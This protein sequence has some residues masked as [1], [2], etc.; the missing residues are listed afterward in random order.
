MWN[1]QNNHKIGCHKLKN[2][3]YDTV[4]T[5]PQSHSNIV[6]RVKIDTP[7]IQIHDRSFSVLIQKLQSNVKWQCRIVYFSIYDN[8][9]YDCSDGSTFLTGNTNNI[10]FMVWPCV[11]K[12]IQLSNIKELHL[13][14]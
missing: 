8:L 10:V 1:H 2:K 11:V 4:E 7:S 12:Q 13:N 3:Q 9:F 5:D 14:F 6:E